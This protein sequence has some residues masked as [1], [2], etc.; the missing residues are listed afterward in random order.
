M[1]KKK[2]PHRPH[3][4]RADAPRWPIHVWARHLTGRHH[5][6]SYSAILSHLARHPRT[7]EGTLTSF[8]LYLA[9]PTCPGHYTKQGRPPHPAIELAIRG[10]EE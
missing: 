2:K 3:R 7:K 6:A 8:D 9:M 10:R 1:A 5:T 4:A